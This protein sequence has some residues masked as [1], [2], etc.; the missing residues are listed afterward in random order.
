MPSDP[1]QRSA[2]DDPTPPPSRPGPRRR[3]WWAAREHVAAARAI[4]LMAAA[5]S[6]WAVLNGI[7]S[8][9]TMGDRA[10]GWLAI[11]AA[12]S[13]VA[14]CGTLLALLP[15]RSPSWAPAALA[16]MAGATVLLLDLWTDDSSFGAQI[17]LGWPA[18]FAAFH[19]RRL[20][21]W[22][23]TAQAVLADVVLMGVEQGSVGVVRDSTAHLVTFCLITALLTSAGERQERL[24][25]SLRAQAA[26]DALTGLTSRRAHDSALAQHVAAGTLD[27]LLLVD[28]DHFKA[29][30][31]THGHPTGDAVLRIVAAELRMVCRSGDVVA[32]L[33]GDEFAVLLVREGPADGSAERDLRAVADR[34]HDAVAASSVPGDPAHRLSVSVGVARTLAGESA[35]ALVARADAAL[36]AAKR[37]G[38]DRVV[39]A[40]P[41]GVGSER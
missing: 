4:G 11:L 31:D 39:D 27:G 2:A 24:T 12:A 21:A 14:L 10:G 38:R 17:Y 26:E 25:A 3:P 5:G 8:P 6:G 32:R 29:V 20:A 37:A 30:N 41:V 13:F 15:R 34:F 22:L 1:Q 9:E 19:L 40:P 28:I 16:G 33:G 18:M 7:L 36:Y 23:L 35:E